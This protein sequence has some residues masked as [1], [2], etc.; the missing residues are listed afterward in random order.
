MMGY[1]I[2]AA[3]FN[4]NYLLYCPGSTN[5]S[6]ACVPENGNPATAQTGSLTGQSNH[7]S[8]TRGGVDRPQRQR[9]YLNRALQHFRSKRC[10]Q[11]VHAFPMEVNIYV[12]GQGCKTCGPT[13]NQTCA[14][15]GGPFDN[16][17]GVFY[18]LDGNDQ[19]C[20]HAHHWA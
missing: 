16:T 18:Y 2:N 14:S 12:S 1:G 8:T 5:A 9:Q 3:D 17:M 6:N 7:G 11:R 4:V 13:P 10:T 20:S 15:T 19:H